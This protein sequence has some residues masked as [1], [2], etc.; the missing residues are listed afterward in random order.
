LGGAAAAG[1]TATVVEGRAERYPVPD[2]LDAIHIQ[3][4]TRYEKKHF[5]ISENYKVRVQPIMN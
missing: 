2:T 1:Q 5:S 4:G 3:D